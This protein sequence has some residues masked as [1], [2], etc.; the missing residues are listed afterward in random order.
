MEKLG[1]QRIS[2]GFTDT[3]HLFW[4]VKCKCE[5]KFAIKEGVGVLSGSDGGMQGMY[6]YSNCNVK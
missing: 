2:R 6:G 5:N 3:V 1:S 4:R